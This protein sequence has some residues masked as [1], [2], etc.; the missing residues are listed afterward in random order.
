MKCNNDQVLR[1]Q[2][3]LTQI[4]VEMEQQINNPFQRIQMWKKW[5]SLTYN[6]KSKKL[7]FV[8]H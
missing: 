7:Y 6:P 1:V 5:F 2:P 3:N 8:I 4:K